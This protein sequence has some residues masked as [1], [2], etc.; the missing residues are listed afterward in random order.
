MAKRVRCRC[1]ACGMLVTQNQ[2]N[3]DYDF[4]FIIQE[5]GSRGRG[6]IYHV[7]RK[8]TKVEGGAF[9]YFKAGLAKKFYQIA[10]RLM[11]EA[12]AEAAKGI[13]EHIPAEEY[14]ELIPSTQIS[15][16]TAY[17]QSGMTE[18]EADNYDRDDIVITELE[19][20]V[21]GEQEWTSLES[22]INPPT[23]MED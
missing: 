22:D 9:V 2:L 15:P 10:D 7:Y 20:K 4:E 3:K 21:G 17:D 18:L 5:T 12:K 11:G 1:P 14:E 6:R 13:Q 19:A 8:P 23:V 16:A